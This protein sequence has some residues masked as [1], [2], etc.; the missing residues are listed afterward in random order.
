[1]TTELSTIS[2]ST[3]IAAP[4]DRVWALVSDLPRMGDYSPE[5]VGG[6]WVGGKGPEVG[7]VFRGRNRQG[8]RRWSTRSEVVRCVP[9]REFAFEVSAVGML[10]AEWAYVV[11]PE[12]AGCRLTETWSDRRNGLMTLLGKV[13]TGVGD[14]GA[15]T[16]T[17]IEQTLA[18]VKERAE[19][20][21]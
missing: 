2:R 11:E 14:R 5:A 12:G 18:R 9:G 13:A 10:A 8:L 1:M 6:S 17:S 4:A 19:R 7:A 15:F 21:E 16:A 3:S 20:Q